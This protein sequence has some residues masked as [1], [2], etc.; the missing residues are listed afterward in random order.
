MYTTL[1]LHNAL[2]CYSIVI[3]IG[4]A[5]FFSTKKAGTEKVR[6]A[7]QSTFHLE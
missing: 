1:T 4:F 3:I 2:K 5:S 6:T 7:K